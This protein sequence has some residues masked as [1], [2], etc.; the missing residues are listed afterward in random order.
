MKTRPS[1]SSK[2]SQFGSQEWLIQRAALPRTDASI[3][4]PSLSSKRNVWYGLSGS[5]S[6]RASASSHDVRLPLYST[7]RMPRGIS[8]AAN[9]PRPWMDERRTM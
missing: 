6:G 4:R 8:I 3:T 1:S 2:G 5:L 9:T 7:M